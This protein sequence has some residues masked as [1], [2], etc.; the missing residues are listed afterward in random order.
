MNQ[1][2]CHQYFKIFLIFL[3]CT[4]QH[5]GTLASLMYAFGIGDGTLIPYAACLIMEVYQ[6]PKGGTVVKVTVKQLFAASWYCVKA[7][8]LK[9]RIFQL[10]YRNQTDSNYLHDTIIPG[11]QEFCPVKK[12]KKLFADMIID[13][14]NELVE[15]NTYMHYMT[16]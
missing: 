15:V 10:L 6:T 5:D 12:L 14:D 9:S 8:N 3:C 1:F 13:D 2:F 11:C 4:I 7:R 16:I